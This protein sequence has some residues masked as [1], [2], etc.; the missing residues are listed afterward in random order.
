MA[1]IAET[2]ANVAGGRAGL[3]SRMYE[4]DQ[5]GET[6]EQGNARRAGA[7]QAVSTY[8]ASRPATNGQQLAQQR[9]LDRQAAADAK[10]H[11]TAYQNEQKQWGIASKYAG[12]IQAAGATEKTTDSGVLNQSV[13]DP[14][15][16]HDST[17]GALI[18][19]LQTARTQAQGLQQTVENLEKK[20]GWGNYRTAQPATTTAP[21]NAPRTNTPPVSAL[22]EGTATKFKN[23]QIWTLRNGQA[24]QLQ[25][26]P[27][28]TPA[29]TAG[30]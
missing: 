16:G 12:A 18:S 14:V 10:A 19:S 24:V 28:A 6:P 7:A 3:V 29:P 21:A 5:P 27:G 2:R 17:V 25:S 1:D 20:N 23:G 26:M 11:S 15:T 9:Y 13:K 4:P 8:D 22:K 30:Q